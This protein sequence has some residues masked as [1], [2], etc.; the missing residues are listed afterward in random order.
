MDELLL[1]FY[2]NDLVAGRLTRDEV[3]AFIEDFYCKNNI[4]IGR[5]EHQMGGSSE[6]STGWARNLCYDAPQ[7]LVLGGR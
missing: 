4:I 6:K 2:R 7:Y 5:G 3:G 1:D